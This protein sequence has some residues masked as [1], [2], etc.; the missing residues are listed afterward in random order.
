[1]GKGKRGK[2]REGEG[3]IG[4]EGR[5]RRGGEGV[6]LLVLLILIAKYDVGQYMRECSS[7]TRCKSLGNV[8]D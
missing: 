4:E 1:V 3:K 5:E 7:Y 2:G 8:H 6:C